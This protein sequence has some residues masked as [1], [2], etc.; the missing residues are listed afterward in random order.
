MY[1]EWG[2]YGKATVLLEQSLN[3]YETYFPYNHDRI[4]WNLT[5]LGDIYAYLGDTAKAVTVL[6]KVSEM[7]KKF[8]TLTHLY[9]IQND[10][11]DIGAIRL[12]KQELKNLIELGLIRN[13]IGHD[14]VRVLLNNDFSSLKVLLLDENN[15]KDYRS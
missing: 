2:K 8:L 10:I 11:D 13:N 7:N 4:V 3:I 9:L 15:L 5:H 12:F 1:R 14:S 6:E